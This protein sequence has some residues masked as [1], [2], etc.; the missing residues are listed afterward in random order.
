MPLSKSKWDVL[1]DKQ[2]R[3]V[4]LTGLADKIAGK[5]AVYHHSR[6]MTNIGFKFCDLY[7]T[8]TSYCGVYGNFRPWKWCVTCI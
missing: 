8:V 7:I 3:G 5:N 2:S 6:H 4:T 1:T